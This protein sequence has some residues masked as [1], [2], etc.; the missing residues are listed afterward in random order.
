MTRW[1]DIWKPRFLQAVWSFVTIDSLFM[2]PPIHLVHYHMLMKLCNQD[3]RIKI[4]INKGKKN[5]ILTLL[6]TLLS[7][8][9]VFVYKGILIVRLNPSFWSYGIFQQLEKWTTRIWLVF[10][11]WY[12]MTQLVLKVEWCRSNIWIY[13]WK[14]S[15]GALRCLGINTWLS[16]TPC[17]SL[18]IYK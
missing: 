10:K 18:Y 6:I 4:E 12:P 3:S 14:S 9:T 5:S 1:R 11:I 15:N 8:C 17:I 7:T 2:G 16:K 13:P